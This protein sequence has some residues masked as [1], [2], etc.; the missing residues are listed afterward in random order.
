M[1]NTLRRLLS[2]KD[3]RE[4][5]KRRLPRMVFDFLEGGADDESG[6]Y[7]NRWAFDQWEFVPRR[8]VDV[9]ERKQ[10]TRLLGQQVPTPL[11]IGP[12]GLN[13]TFWPSGDLALARAAAK[14][15]IPFALSTASNMSIEEV[16]R[17]AD[18]DLWFQLYVVH[19]NLANSLVGRARAAGYST[20]ILTTD[21]A[22]NGFRE[23]D[24]RNGFKIPFNP[25]VR[26]VADG[27]CHPGWLWSYLT[28]GIPQLRNFATNGAVNTPSQV[29]I[30]RREMDASFCWD[31]L[32]RLRDEWPGKL[33]VK[34]ILGLADAQRCVE[35]GVDGIVVSNHGA[36]Q[37]ADLPAS[38]D[39]LARI[40][41]LSH[42]TSVI[43]DSG[44]RRG[45]DV[46]KAV[47]M[48]ASAVML[49]R[50]PLYGLAAA[51]EAGVSA[52]LELLK[53]EIDRTQALIGCQAINQLDSSWISQRWAQKPT[54]ENARIIE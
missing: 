10:L 41:H 14:A 38:L 22:V 42:S 32:R 45:A 49:G 23:R 36:R 25:S 33:L 27:L 2:V 16:A 40:S 52:V 30:L 24:L 39:A 8:L 15:G 20:L 34:G 12:T 44:V 43:L 4:A 6:L 26:A 50:A 54:S 13:G 46:V 3:Y 35:I 51:G 21:V 29:A 11:I 37:L 9:S 7:N 5:A 18:G 17:G 31:D 53:D 19:R 48:G 47:A 1:I 28:G